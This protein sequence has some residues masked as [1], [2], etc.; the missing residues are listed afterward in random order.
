MNFVK[1]KIVEKNP[2]ITIDKNWL[3]YKNFVNQKEFDKINHIIELYI[4]KY[5]TNKV[6]VGYEVIVKD[7]DDNPS[8]ILIV[9]KAK[10]DFLRET[11][12]TYTLSRQLFSA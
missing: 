11:E 12:S 5:G 2:S 4:N 1:L 7:L 6:Q 9:C 3:P 8:E 10:T